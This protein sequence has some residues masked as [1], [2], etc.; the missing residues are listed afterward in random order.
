VSGADDLHRLFGR[1]T[2]YRPLPNA[3]VP[4]FEN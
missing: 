2:G 3:R 1:F 4:T